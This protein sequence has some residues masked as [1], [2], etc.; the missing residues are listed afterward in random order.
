[1][2]YWVRHYSHQL[3]QWQCLVHL[4]LALAPTMDARFE[5][6]GKGNFL[7]FLCWEGVSYAPCQIGWITRL[8]PVIHSRKHWKQ[9]FASLVDDPDMLITSSTFWNRVVGSS[10]SFKLIDR[11][12]PRV[13]NSSASW[14]AYSLLLLFKWV[15]LSK[16]QIKLKKVQREGQSFLFFHKQRSVTGGVGYPM[17]D[18][19]S[20][21]WAS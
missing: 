1:M 4:G 18:G 7:G 13:L 12:T 15:Y 2:K 20:F 10:H 6:Q 9:M 21:I 17:A 5:K 3:A 16:Y 8:C 11:G 19:F 14:K